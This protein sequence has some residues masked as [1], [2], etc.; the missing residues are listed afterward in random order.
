MANMFRASSQEEKEEKYVFFLTDS[1]L[2]FFIS[3]VYYQE[4]SL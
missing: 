2:S 1:L 4:P 3:L